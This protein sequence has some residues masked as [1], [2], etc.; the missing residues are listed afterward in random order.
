[1]R[2][3]WLQARPAGIPILAMFELFLKENVSNTSPFQKQTLPNLRNSTGPGRG[4]RNDGGRERRREVLYEMCYGS[5]VRVS[6][7]LG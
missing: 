7:W 1:M 4:T 5:T 2:V 3:C 6:E